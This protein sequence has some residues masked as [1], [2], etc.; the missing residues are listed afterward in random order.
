MAHGGRVQCPPAAGQLSSLDGVVAYW[1]EPVAAWLPGQQ[2]AS[3]FHVFLLH[4]RLA[5][6]LWPVWEAEQ[7][8]GETA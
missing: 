7:G 1:G 6:G 8:T 2:H 3:C 4:H 5:R